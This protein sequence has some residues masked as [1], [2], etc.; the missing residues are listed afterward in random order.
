MAPSVYEFVFF[1]VRPEI[2]PEDPEFNQESDSLLNLLRDTK[3]QHGYQ[4]SA[5]GRTVEDEN[6]LVW[7]VGL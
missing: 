2:K 7:V 1:I 4:A 3:Q 6:A 5:W